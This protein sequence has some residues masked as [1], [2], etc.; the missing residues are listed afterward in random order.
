MFVDRTLRALL[1]RTLSVLAGVTAGPSALGADTKADSKNECIS[2]AD[3]GQS[4]RD[5]GHYRA[6]HAAFLRCARDACPAIIA[7]SCSDWLRRLEDA[8]PTVVLSARDERGNPLSTVPVTLDGALL[9]DALDGRGVAVDPGEH[10]FRFE[11]AARAPAEVRVTLR[12]GEKNVRVDVTLA[13]V[14]APGGATSTPTPPSIAGGDV[15][16]SEAPLSPPSQPTVHPSSSATPLW[17]PRS[18]LVL[19]LLAGASAS[20]G[21]AAYLF[22]QSGSES[23]VARGVRST[24]PS[25][26]C[27]HDP[28]TATC[29]RLS[30]A[31]DAQHLDSTLGA[32]MAVGAGLLVVTAGVT[33]L[34]WPTPREHAGVSWIG[35]RLAPGRAGLDVGGEF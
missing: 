34:A 32:A 4:L 5:D 29:R 35:P 16:A 26:A 30:D 9:V 11:Q 18:V 8:T 7:R 33:W 22:A 31:V 28:T 6:A 24:V 14:A 17:S 2:A 20:V 15:P 3:A 12:A 27:T 13:A 23:N 21:G 1:L 25:D 19:S 10:V